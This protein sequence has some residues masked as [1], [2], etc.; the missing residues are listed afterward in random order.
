MPCRIRLAAATG[1]FPMLQVGN[2]PD[3][4]HASPQR[5]SPHFCPLLRH[6]LPARSILATPL[7][8]IPDTDGPHLHLIATV[9]IPPVGYG[10]SIHS[11]RGNT[12]SLMDVA[13]DANAVLSLGLA[14]PAFS[15]LRDSLRKTKSRLLLPEETP[16]EF[17]RDMVPA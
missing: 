9:K 2:Y 4:V 16:S 8:V 14:N 3:V 10:P 1:S 11:P 17:P 6:R 7:A 13:L 12:L 15:P 5:A